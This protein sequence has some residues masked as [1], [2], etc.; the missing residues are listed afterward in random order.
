MRQLVFVILLFLVASPAFADK[1]LTFAMPDD[2]IAYTSLAVLK[3]AYSRLDLKVEGLTLPASRALEESDAGRTDGEVNRIAAIENAHPN[4]IRVPVPVN[5]LEGVAYSC[6]KKIHVE[7]WESLRGYRIGIRNGI[8]FAERGTEGLPNVTRATDYDVLF[9][10]LFVG[11]L[12][13]VIASRQV[14]SLQFRRSGMDCLVVNEPP[15]TSLPL[16]HYLNK[17]HVTLVPA[18]THILQ[19]MVDTGEAEALRQEATTELF[20]HAP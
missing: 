14:G 3:E 15:L 17:R 13:V 10:L 18:L 7:G 5:F 4:L 16:Y 20:A 2:E 6:R 12:D 9:E 1:T 8:K 11:R 19:E